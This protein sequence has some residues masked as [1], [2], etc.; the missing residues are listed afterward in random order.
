M[1]TSKQVV[2]LYGKDKGVGL[3]KKRRRVILAPWVPTPDD[4]VEEIMKIA[5]VG[6]GDTVCDLGCGDGRMLIAAV[7]NYGA[8]KAIGY[9]IKE[10]LCNLSMQEIQKQGLQQQIEIRQENMLNAD[11]SEISV[12]AM[13]QSTKTNE[14][15]RRKLEKE[16]KPGTRVVTYGFQ[17]RKWQSKNQA[18]I[19]D[20]GYGDFHTVYLYVVPEAF[21]QNNLTD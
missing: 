3:R 4:A 19:F 10:E 8:K 20:H 11:I 15:L 7:K 6:E 16:M 13:Y 18:Q 1:N 2:S 14:I 12:L 21:T 5:S 17:I 9:E